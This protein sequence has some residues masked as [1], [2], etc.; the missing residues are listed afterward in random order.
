MVAESKRQTYE[1]SRGKPMQMVGIT[2]R[3]TE[4][5]TVSPVPRAVENI[6]GISWVPSRTYV[7]GL[8]TNRLEDGESLDTMTAVSVR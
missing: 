6:A 2:V 1:R 4:T 8:N 3:Y 5:W 7:I